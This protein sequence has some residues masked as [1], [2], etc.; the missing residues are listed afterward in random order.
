MKQTFLRI[1]SAAAAIC[2]ICSGCTLWAETPAAVPAPTGA[3][4]QSC[5]EFMQRR[6]TGQGVYT[7][8]LE[9]KNSE[10]LA[11]GREVLSESQGLMLRY[12]AARS[13]RKGYAGTV[14]FIQEKLDTGI[15]FSYRVKPEGFRY[16]VNAAVDDLRILRGFLEGAEVFSAPEYADQC[17]IYAGRLYET[18]VRDGLLLDF[19]DEDYAAARNLSTLCYSDFKTMEL[20]GTKDQRWLTVE[21][22]ML[23]VALGGYLGDE[24]PFFRTRY[25]P[26]TH[27][28]SEGNLRTVESLLTALHLSEVGRCPEGTI[29]WLKAALA[30]G[31]VYGEYTQV[32]EPVTEV[33]STAIYALCALLGINEGEPEL[34]RAAMERLLS[35]QITDPASALYGA[36]AD[37]VSGQAYSFDNLTAL[38][39]LR[40]QAEYLAVEERGK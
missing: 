17:A 26:D 27:S 7:S 12:Y 34:V 11:T 37:K 32:G 39:A 4:E 31:A 24:F 22:R 5:L 10:D 20:L 36:F 2:L 21:E 6:M 35:F 1:F 14:S 23:G 3:A 30:A 19:Y 29:R 16:P 13:D 33:Q 18:N 28:Y 9:E 40:A 15:L 8:L 38:T 25:L